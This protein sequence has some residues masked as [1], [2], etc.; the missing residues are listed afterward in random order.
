MQ[1]EKHYYQKKCLPEGLVYVKSHL[2]DTDGGM[3]FTVGS[4]KEIN[5]IITGSSNIPL[6]KV[7]VKP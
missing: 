7:N 6:I 4:L 5:N 1:Q 2:I 3:C